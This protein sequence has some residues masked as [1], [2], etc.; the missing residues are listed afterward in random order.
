MVLVGFHLSAGAGM[1][2]HCGFAAGTPGGPMS[3]PAVQAHLWLPSCQALVTQLLSPAEP[4]FHV[5]GLHWAAL[6][7]SHCC[8]HTCNVSPI[9]TPGL[10]LTVRTPSINQPR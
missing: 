3:P 5:M 9:T 1:L 6:P 8:S 7:L 4:L 10:R 2:G